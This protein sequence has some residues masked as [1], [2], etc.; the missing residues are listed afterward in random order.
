MAI[1]IGVEASEIMAAVAMLMPDTDLDTYSKNYKGLV[2]FL[3]A[4]KKLADGKKCVYSTGTKDKFL[5]AFEG[6]N[7]GRIT[8]M[9]PPSEQFLGEAIKG[10]SAA[11]SI[12][13]WVPVRSAESGKAI[14]G[15]NLVAES[16]F[17]TGDKWPAEVQQFSVNAYGFKAYNSSDVIFK[18]KNPAGLS[19]YGV[20]LKK[21]ETP[22][23][24]D[25]PLINKAFDSVLAGQGTTQIKK[26]EECKDKVVKARTKY[27]AK[28]VREAT[29]AGYIKFVGKNLS[30]FSDEEL[31]KLRIN[32]PGFAKEPMA[33]IDIKGSGVVNLKDPK[34]QPKADEYKSIFKIKAG[35]SW[36]EF[37]PGEMKNKDLSFRAYVN[38]RIASKDS[39]YEEM[40]KVMDNYSEMFAESLLNLVLKKN[41]YEHLEEHTFG[42]ALVTGV[43]DVDKEGNPKGLHIK[44]AQGLYTIL[45]GLSALNKG[46]AKYKM[47]INKS[48]T[49]KSESAGVHLMLKK[50]D[51][52]VLEMTLR[53]K[54]GF[55]GQAQFMG[56]LA[57]PFVE[58]LKEQWGKKCRVPK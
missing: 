16:S 32:M 11:K 40:R 14:I 39:V 56:T 8:N 2:D 50:G 47:V 35:S 7:G 19:Y 43:G 24:G 37:L 9:N 31:Y 57:P 6:M 28:V 45:C 26:I 53:Y 4:G 46:T 42:F 12:R 27:F 58:I 23:A 30:S 34:N 17:L 49:E 21:K 41:L 54:G 10:I 38:G 5:K 48:K 33:L 22:S 25:P 15:K 20:S 1:K 52:D 51:I 13:Q 36:R 18:F 44:P 3:K 55:T 29:K